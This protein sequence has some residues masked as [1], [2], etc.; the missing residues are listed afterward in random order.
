MNKMKSFL[1][2]AG[3]VSVVALAVVVALVTATSPDQPSA[4]ATEAIPPTEAV[5]VFNVGTSDA[6]TGTL[7]LT[8][9]TPKDPVL[10][11]GA[12]KGLPGNSTHGFHVHESGDVRNGCTST[13]GH[14]NPAKA[15]HAAQSDTI[16]HVGDLGNIK[17]DQSGIADLE[18]SDSVISLSGPNSIVGRAIVVHQL[19]DDLGKGGNADSLK[20]GNA[21]A[22]LKCGVIGVIYKSA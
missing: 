7:V 12:I 18:I 11:K 17:S 14:F 10:I 2:V 6:V 21:G 4:S 22:R 3:V 15:T 13:G 8:Q 19:E 5:V 16:R 1:I 9:P 20:T